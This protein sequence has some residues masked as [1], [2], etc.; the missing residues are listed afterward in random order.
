MKYKVKKLP[1]N[2]YEIENTL[3]KEKTVISKTGLEKGIT[4]LEKEILVKQSILNYR[5]TLLIEVNK[6]K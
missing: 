6:I 3:T 1:K 4:E 2:E 5:K